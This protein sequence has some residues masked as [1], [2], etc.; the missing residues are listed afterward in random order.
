VQAWILNDV[1]YR[2]EPTNPYRQI[3][4]A[5]FESM[6]GDLGIRNTWSIV[7]LLGYR[8]SEHLLIDPRLLDLE[9]VLIQVKPRKTSASYLS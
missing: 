7:E 6:V 5:A 2:I 1:Y 8:V 9:H 3:D 4:F